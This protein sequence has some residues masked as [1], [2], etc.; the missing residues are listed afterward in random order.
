MTRR[1]FLRNGRA[2]EET[3]VVFF[4]DGIFAMEEVTNLP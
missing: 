1:N 3:R 4:A 2:E